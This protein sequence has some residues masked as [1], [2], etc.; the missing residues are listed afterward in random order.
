MESLPNEI[1]E[2]IFLRLPQ[3]CKTTAS[4]VCKAWYHFIQPY[5]FI[6]TDVYSQQQLIRFIKLAKEKTINNKLIGHYV[7]HLNVNI[8]IDD[9]KKELLL[10]I[11]KTF[12]NIHSIDGL[13]VSD[14]IPED[15]YLPE[16]KQL[17]HYEEWY[18][19][20]YKSWM[21]TL[22]NNEDKVEYLDISEN[23][24]LELIDDKKQYSVPLR[25]SI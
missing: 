24:E 23:I 4:T 7:Q 10:E 21:T 13:Y 2:N 12:P 5:L 6:S 18:M 19:N 1:L 11:A 14:N 16:L 15:D 8:Y 3:T 20:G 17:T 25:L 22:Y 9:T